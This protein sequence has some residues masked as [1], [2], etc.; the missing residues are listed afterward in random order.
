[1]I[2][3]GVVSG[4]WVYRQPENNVGRGFRLKPLQNANGSL[5]SKMERRLVAKWFIQHSF[6]G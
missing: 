4:C 5:K 6:V 1:M 2:G 3:V